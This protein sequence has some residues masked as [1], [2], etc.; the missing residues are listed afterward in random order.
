MKKC[1]SFKMFAAA[2]AVL[3][4]FPFASQADDAKFV[5]GKDVPQEYVN[6]QGTPFVLIP[7][8]E[9][10]MGSDIHARNAEN[11]CSNTGPCHLVKHSKPFYM[12]KFVVTHEE[13]EKFVNATGYETAAEKAGIGSTYRVE[14]RDGGRYGNW[15]MIEGCTWRTPGIDI[16]P[17]HPACTINFFDVK[18]YI[19]WLNTVEKPE[20]DFGVP[21]VYR[22]PTEAEW[23]Y[24]CRAGTTTDFFWGDRAEDGKGY[25]CCAGTEGAPLDAV[26]GEHFPFDDGFIA[27]AP[28]GSFKPNPFGLYD[29]LGLVWEWVGDYYAPDYFQHSP[30]V[31]PKGPEKG[32]EK[33]TVIARGG[34]WGQDQFY[35]NCWARRPIDPHYG[36]CA[37]G[38]RLVLVPCDR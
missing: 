34:C 12:G 30:E 37:L 9:F 25:L 38:F 28:V 21:C 3:L 32:D 11:Y 26:W 2:C 18:A 35:N 6:G 23:E 24:A 15:G 20:N 13:Y 10:M 1:M 8:G 27:S 4:A 31:D 5:E 19:D 16:S 33:G 36:G 14:E 17:R 7:A 22:L 29:M